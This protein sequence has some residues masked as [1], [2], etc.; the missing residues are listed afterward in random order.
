MRRSTYSVVSV[1]SMDDEDDEECVEES[2]P[3]SLLLSVT[4]VI[5]FPRAQ[6]VAVPLPGR[7]YWRRL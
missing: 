3:V 1:D 7:F 4:L 5:D 2:D 6:L